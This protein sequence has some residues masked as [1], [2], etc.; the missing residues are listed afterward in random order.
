M[1]LVGELDAIE[2]SFLEQ[3]YTKERNPSNSSAGGGVEVR[4]FYRTHYNV[5]VMSAINAH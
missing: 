4:A 5:F 3:G 1:E 2:A